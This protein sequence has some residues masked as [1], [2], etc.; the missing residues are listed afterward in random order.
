MNGAGGPSTPRGAARRAGG[1]GAR[2]A[3]RR[4]P[5]A[6]PPEAVW[7]VPGL[8]PAVPAGRAAEGAPEH[9]EPLRGPVETLPE[10]ADVVLVSVRQK[11]PSRGCEFA[12]GPPR[13]WT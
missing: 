10:L 6:V 2:D 8:A 7:A 12:G 1:V 3:L 9:I 11:T 13:P 5:P 4:V